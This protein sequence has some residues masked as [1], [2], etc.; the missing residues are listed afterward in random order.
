[1]KLTKK[2]IA[3]MKRIISYERDANERYKR[4]GA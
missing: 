3:A 4:D 1:M 2:Q